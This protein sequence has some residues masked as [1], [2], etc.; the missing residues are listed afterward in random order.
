MGVT[1][2]EYRSRIGSF[3]LPDSR[4]SKKKPLVSKTNSSFEEYIPLLI[5]F[6]G[7]LSIYC[8]AYQ[9]LPPSLNHNNPNDPAMLSKPAP[10]PTSTRSRPLSPSASFWISN[11]E[12]NRIARA[13]N[14][15]NRNKACSLE[16]WKCPS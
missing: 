8:T 14:G 5:L 4:T 7:L 10:A 11:K 9:I 12:K 2:Q 1:L 3:Y 13:T 16:C 6:A 15:N